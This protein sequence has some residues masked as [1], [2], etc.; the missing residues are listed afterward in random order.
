MK[1][2][3]LTSFILSTIL[4]SSTLLVGCNDSK[5][6]AEKTTPEKAEIT[7][8]AVVYD[9]LNPKSMLLAVS[10]ACGGLD[11]LKSLNDVQYDYHYVAPDGKSDISVERYIFDNEISWARYSKHELN[12][13][14]E[15][16]GDIVQY[17]DGEKPAVYHNGIAVSDTMAIGMGHFLRQANYMWFN[18]MFKLNDPGILYDYKGQTTI[19]GTTYD[20]V[21]I[22]YDPAVT[23]KE[24]NDIYLVHINPENKMID[25]F[26]FSLPALGVMDPVLHAQLTYSNIDGIQVITK[27]VMTGPAPDG[28][29]MVPLVDQQ[30]KNVSFNNGF[31]AEQ[32]SKD[33]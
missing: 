19:D 8:V 2:Y 29:G 23:G 24:Q 11:K 25:S 28:S 9:T 1:N 20:S 6:S 4:I 17:Y 3:S 33:I 18:M 14:P 12:V 10:E 27:R 7:K 32:L 5:K 21:H 15:L 16:E 22:T 26:Y 31:T 13:S 30:L